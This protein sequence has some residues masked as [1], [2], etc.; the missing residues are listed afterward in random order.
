MKAIVVVT[1]KVP[2]RDLA[3]AA[4]TNPAAN[5]AAL[6]DAITVAQ[7]AHTAGIPIFMVTVAQSPAMAG[8]L[9]TQF[10]DTQ[11]GGLVNT[12]GS[13]GTLYVE[14]WVSPQATYTSLVGD[15]N[16]VIR[17]LMTLVQG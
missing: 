4:F 16:N 11:P 10:S 1:D 5:G 3:G 17:Q 8:Y 12:A 7:A 9:T 13:G 15:F 6:G 2:S 14:N